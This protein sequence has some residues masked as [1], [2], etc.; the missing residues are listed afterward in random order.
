MV[1]SL[2]EGANA[3]PAI[4]QLAP[5]KKKDKAGKKRVALIN[6]SSTTRTGGAGA[7][8]LNETSKKTEGGINILQVKSKKKIK[9]QLISP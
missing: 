2:P 7:G 5:R 6:L 4:N 8:L 3:T 1:S 9:P